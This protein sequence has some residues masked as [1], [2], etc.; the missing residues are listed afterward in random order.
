ME[1]DVKTLRKSGVPNVRHMPRYLNGTEMMYLGVQTSASVI[2]LIDIE[3]TCIHKDFDHKPYEV[4]LS[5][6]IKKL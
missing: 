1:T 4:D 3:S 2:S 5:E 6:A